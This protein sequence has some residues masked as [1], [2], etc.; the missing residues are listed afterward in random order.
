VTI[1][2]GT[3]PPDPGLAVL[4]RAAYANATIFFHEEIV[5]MVSTLQDRLSPGH[6]DVLISSQGTGLLRR[7]IHH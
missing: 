4:I 6:I 5:A 1:V 2:I 3:P 7:D